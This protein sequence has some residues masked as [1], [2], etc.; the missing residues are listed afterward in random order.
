MECF[1]EDLLNLNQMREGAFSLIKDPFDP[2]AVLNFIQDMFA[3][4]AEAK[5]IDIRL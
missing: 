4:R 2:H 5:G 1:V 3:P